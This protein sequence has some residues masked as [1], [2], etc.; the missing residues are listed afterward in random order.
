[1]KAGG[2]RARQMKRNIIANVI[3][4]VILTFW[5]GQQIRMS[6]FDR[7]HAVFILPYAI[8]DLAGLS[9]LV[10]SMKNK[11]R[12]IEDSSFIFILCIVTVN[13]PILIGVLGQNLAG[14]PLYPNV[15]AVA[16]FM[17][18]F[19]VSFYLPAVFNLGKRIS[20]LPV[21]TSLEMT[22]IYS[23]ARHPLYST[24]IYWYILQVLIFQSWTIAAISSAQICFQIVRARSEEKVLE[25]N[26][27]EYAAYRKRVW[28]IGR[29]P[30]A[31][32]SA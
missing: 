4:M 19:A 9:M 16:G 27:P 31:K 2:K 15:R 21:A 13:L 7:Y 22:G 12:E 1:M 26:F 28:W 18:L 14:V 10:L 32:G 25:R 11:P 30:F 8:S 17:S 20:V 29:N 24:Y 23:F 5:V 3:T 6:M